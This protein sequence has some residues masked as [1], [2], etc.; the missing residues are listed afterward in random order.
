MIKHGRKKITLAEIKRSVRIFS[1]LCAIFVFAIGVLIAWNFININNTLVG[2][3]LVVFFLFAF[4]LEKT[5]F[6]IGMKKAK[7]KHAEALGEVIVVKWG[8][9]KIA[10]F[11]FL[12]II[13]SSL[14]FII[15][16]LFF[17]P[18]IDVVQADDV[19]LG[20]HRGDSMEY[21]ENTLPAIQGAIEDERYK[22]IEFDVQ[23]TKDK[24]LIVYHDLSLFRLQKK[25]IYIEDLT[26]EELLEVSDYHIP[27]YSEVMDMIGE[28][29]P[30]N[31][32][33]KSQ[34]NYADD[35]NSVDFIVS[36]CKER[37]VFDTTLFS[38][39]SRDVIIYLDEQYPEAKTGIIYY[40]D[41]ST[42]LNFENIVDGIYDDT[43]EIG[44]DYLMLH[45]SNLR[46]YYALQNLKPAEIDIVIWY[47]NDEMYIIPSDS[48]IVDKDGYLTG[49][50]IN[51]GSN[52]L[53]SW[54]L[55][56]GSKRI[57]GNKNKF[58]SW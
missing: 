44:A 9:R 23:Y 54:D 18:N 24:K 13:S 52:W 41:Y 22:F 53:G 6:S 32:E 45:A 12:T 25:L 10:G 55:M 21:I 15:F 49:Y 56:F 33:I 40:I 57:F 48:S 17:I 1:Y 8:K 58:S 26:Y 19:I 20:A 37:G 3:S 11:S 16:I 2:L 14:F 46:N 42:L 51:A 27:L 43:K 31:V 7:K 5:V 38:S 47:F 36:D 34:G 39:I 28:R 29:K 50:A 30:L 35:I 4:T